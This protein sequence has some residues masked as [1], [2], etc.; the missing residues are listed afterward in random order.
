MTSP[1]YAYPNHPSS[2]SQSFSRHLAASRPDSSSLVTVARLRP[3]PAD[4]PAPPASS[5]PAPCHPTGLLMALPPRSSP[6]DIPTRG[7]A[8]QSTRLPPPTPPEPNDNTMEDHVRERVEA[9]LGLV[10]WTINRYYRRL[11]DDD[12]VLQAGRLGLIRAAEKFDPELGF[13]FGTYAPNWIRSFI[14]KHLNGDRPDA[15]KRQGTV[16]SLDMMLGDD[17][18]LAL[19]DIIPDETI[20]LERD[21]ERDDLRQRMK[22]FVASLGERDRVIVRELLRGRSLTDAATKLG[23]T[24]QHL[25]ANVWPNLARR[26]RREFADFA[27]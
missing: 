27:S 20:D 2:T 6:S 12:D 25:Y 10:H 17:G 5:L 21:A 11:A 9:N 26:L 3:I 4:M 24:P 15:K 18:T 23:V 7:M 13:A 22:D 16:I 8:P 14:G 1:A 19:S